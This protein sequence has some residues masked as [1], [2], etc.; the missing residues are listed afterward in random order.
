MN[1]GKIIKW[2]PERGFGFIKPHSG[3]EEIF[4]HISDLKN[5]SYHPRVG[6]KV[7][8]HIGKGKKDKKKAVLVH[9]VEGDM[10]I[11]NKKHPKTFFSNRMKRR[12]GIFIVL[13]GMML[14]VQKCNFVTDVV[15]DRRIEVSTPYELHDK[16]NI[17]DIDVTIHEDD[18]MDDTDAFIKKHTRHSAFT[19]ESVFTIK[20]EE[21]LKQPYH[22]DGRVYCSQMHSCDEAKYFIT[23]CSGTKMDGDGD[24][25]PCESQW[26][27]H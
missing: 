3:T 15:H 23:H 16:N 10:D 22:C 24:G 12:I 18:G 19:T 6:D 17:E 26:C 27:G 20:S 4:V 8:Y 25:I 1:K 2:N 21:N 5:R 11:S 7:F 9:L 13:G 14:F